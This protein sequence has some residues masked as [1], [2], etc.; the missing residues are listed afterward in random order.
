MYVITSYILEA[1]KS[2]ARMMPHNGGVQQ[3]TGFLLSLGSSI[4]HRLIMVKARLVLLLV[5]CA[6]IMIT[7]MLTW[8]FSLNATERSCNNVSAQLRQDVT[9]SAMEALTGFLMRTTTASHSLHRAMDGLGTDYSAE[10]YP[11]VLLPLMWGVFSTNPEFGTVHIATQADDQGG[12]RRDG[13]EAPLLGNREAVGV[14]S[15]PN[16]TRSLTYG[17]IPDPETGRPRTDGPKLFLCA[18]NISCPEVM[19]PALYVPATLPPTKGASWRAGL[20]LAKGKI[21]MTIGMMSNICNQTFRPCRVF[22]TRRTNR[23]HAVLSIASSSTRLREFLQS[24]SLVRH[25]NGHIFIVEGASM[26][27]LSATSGPLYT[28]PAA[29]GG[30]PTFLSAMD[31]S[32]DVIRETARVVNT[33]N[34]AQMFTQPIQTRARLSGHGVYYINATPL[35]YEGLQLLVILAVPRE[36]FHGDLAASRRQGLIFTMVIVLIMFVVGGLAMCL[37][38][39]GASKKLE[40]QEK[41]LNEASAANRALREQLLVMTQVYADDWAQ[42]DM[43]T[44]LEK[45]TAIIKQLR[46]G[47]FLSHAQVQQMQAL[48]TADDLHKP[49]F[50]TNI[51]SKDAGDSVSGSLSRVDSETGN[52]IELIAM[53]RRVGPEARQDPV[54]SQTPTRSPRSFARNVQRIFRQ[55]R[56]RPSLLLDTGGEYTRASGSS[57]NAS[58]SGSGQ[59]LAS[60]QDSGVDAAPLRTD[61][62]ASSPCA[63]DK[64]TGGSKDRVHSFSGHQAEPVRPANVRFLHLF[65]HTMGSMEPRTLQVMRRVAML[66]L[67]AAKA[68]CGGEIPGAATPSIAQLRQVAGI[69]TVRQPISASE[70]SLGS[71]GQGKEA[72]G[73]HS[74]VANLLAPPSPEQQQQ[75]SLLRTIGEWEFDTLAM[76]AVT[77]EGILPLV[78]YTLFLREGLILEFGI[79]EHKL[80]NFLL[81]IARGMD[82]HPYHNAGHVVDV[83]ASLVH[84]LDHSGVGDHLRGIDKLAALC[85]A[86]IHDYK[87]PG[88]NND[89]LSRTRDELATIYNDKSPLENYHLAEAFQLL[90]SNEHCNFLDVLSEKDFMEVRCIMIE[91]VLASDLKRHFGVLDAFKARVSQE[92]AWDLKRDSDRILL[93][94]LAL[95]VADV[96]HTAKPLRT[97]VAWTQRV[98]EE[99]YQQGDGERALD[100]NVSPFMDRKNNNFARSQVG[101]FQFLAMP[102]MDAWVKSFPRSAHLLSHMSANIEHW[103]RELQSGTSNAAQCLV[104]HN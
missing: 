97:H 39:T 27:V 26:R 20:A 41:D 22:E 24:T 2:A 36:E 79:D 103:R 70:T 1:C 15:L 102:L 23:W 19:D 4:S 28:P 50:L 8:K 73:G 10:S 76:E 54:A 16:D 87:H 61:A 84:I 49:Q 40:T 99:F 46:P 74:G 42:V 18:I 83:T 55:L 5:I 101:F 48:I 59:H 104:S 82:A 33:T 81:Q 47:R 88:V 45:L 80:A 3:R 52:W 72:S 17:Y 71:V 64:R 38:T 31:S 21:K 57:T 91:M 67:P 35:D 7:A 58:P 14:P 34:G 6:A 90:Y 44:P 85:A 30:R 78:G 11:T 92:H 77:G 95:K 56:R 25:F 65:G 93:L 98:C 51:K 13:P 29:P 37:S 32:D 69:M 66:S 62:A 86:L 96:G 43:G 100:L 68:V 60:L 12:Y 94:Q 63:D 9:Q 75:I 89:F 53:G